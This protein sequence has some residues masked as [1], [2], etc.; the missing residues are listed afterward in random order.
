MPARRTTGRRPRR[1]TGY[2]KRTGLRRKPTMARIARQ[3]R[4]LASQSNAEKK[5]FGPIIMTDID[6]PST[7]PV[8]LCDGTN[9]LGGG[10]II[11]LRPTIS[12]GVTGDDRIGNSVRLHAMHL[13]ICVAGQSTQS[14]NSQLS[15]EVFRV[16]GYKPYEGSTRDWNGMGKDLF[17]P[18][19][20]TG[21]FPID[22]TRNPNY[23]AQFTLLRRK[24]IS[25]PQDNGGTS[26]FLRKFNIGI[27]FPKYHLRW[28]DAGNQLTQLILVVRASNGNCSVAS[29]ALT[30]QSMLGLNSAV[31]TGFVY[32]CIADY[33][34]YDD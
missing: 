11:D 34:Y 4:T 24:V 6:G 33:Y 2:R 7:I 13:K 30:A 16:N 22:C 20:L 1:K 21:L 14:M 32:N 27:K 3:V 8:G 19:P 31:N 25:T 29:A 15:F 9:T 12:Q 17:K 10:S 5:H 23:Y 26:N 28:D 18:D